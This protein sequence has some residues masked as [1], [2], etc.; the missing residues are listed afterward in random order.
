VTGSLKEAGLQESVRTN[1]NCIRGTVLWVSNHIF[2]KP[3]ANEQNCVDAAGI[4]STNKCLTRGDL[5]EFIEKSAEAIVPVE[6]E[7]YGKDT[8]GLTK[9]GRAER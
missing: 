4:D 7:P 1:R 5:D 9:Q 6:Y 3:L 8:E 2:T